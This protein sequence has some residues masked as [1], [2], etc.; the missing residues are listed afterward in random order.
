MSRRIKPVAI[1]VAV[2][3]TAQLYGAIKSSL[4]M[5]PNLFQSIATS[6]QALKTFLGIGEGL[7]GGQLNGT[8]RE[9]IALAVA[10]KNGC[11]YCLSAHSLLSKLGGAAPDE[12]LRN[13]RGESKDVK[14]TAL[15][16]LASEIVSEKG[17]VSDVTFKNFL[18][19]GYTESHLPEV[20][21]VVVENLYTNYFNNFNRTEIDFPVVEKLKA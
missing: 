4:G 16:R 1:E 3:E 19:Q 8:D 17:R 7:K 18:A 9:A 15:L 14:R 21:L 13:R 12:I 11:D 5:V 20:L 2:G 6:P 10:E